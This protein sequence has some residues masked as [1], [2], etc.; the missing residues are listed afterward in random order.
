MEERARGGE[1]PPESAAAGVAER[2]SSEG[3]ARATRRVLI[4]DDSPVIRSVVQI[5]LR[6]RGLEFEEAADGQRALALARLVPFDLVIADVR[7][8]GMDGIRF[9]AALREGAG[10][11]PA[12]VPVILVTGEKS[13]ETWRRCQ[14]S[15]ATVVL[16]KPVSSAGLLDAVAQ[17]LGP[18]GGPGA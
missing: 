13:T 12:T 2:G 1:R 10:A 6:D 5:Y 8:P 15:G 14:A 7:M 17:A 4:A 18:G 16:K 11:T 3:G 9:V